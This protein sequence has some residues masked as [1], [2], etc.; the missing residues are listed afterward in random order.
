[1]AVELCEPQ[2]SCGRRTWEL[3]GAVKFPMSRSPIELKLGGTQSGSDPAPRT[4][5]RRT[6]R[7]GW[8]VRSSGVPQGGFV[9]GAFEDRQPIVC[10]ME[11][12]DISILQFGL[13]GVLATSQRWRDLWP[14]IEIKAVIDVTLMR[15]DQGNAPGC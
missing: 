11:V 3:Y 7:F 2:L 8:L 4:G 13:D 5:F 14:T 1:M 12:S 15:F 9:S 10:K 6:A